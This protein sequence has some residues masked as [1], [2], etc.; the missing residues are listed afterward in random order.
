MV[1]V[2]ACWTLL[3][4]WT[5]RHSSSSA[6]PHAAAQVDLM[7]SREVEDASRL[8]KPLKVAVMGCV[9]NGPGEAADADIGVACGVGSGVVFSKGNVVRKV[10]ESAIVDALME[11]IGKL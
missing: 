4:A 11:E 1:E 10:E 7:G 2:L 5:R 8:D 9:V 3:G 6:V